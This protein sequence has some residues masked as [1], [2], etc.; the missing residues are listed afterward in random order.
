MIFLSTE[1][2]VEIHEEMISAWGG[3]A[4]G[5]P[6]GDSYEGVEAACQ[7]V[8]N[9][10]YEDLA[11]LAAAYAVY[12]VQGHVFADGNKRTGAGAMLVFLELNGA[13]TGISLED[14]A[15]AMVELQVRARKGERTDRLIAWLAKS[16]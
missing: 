3:A 6:R 15:S 12:I 10:Y 11:E 2:I 16:L 5:G 13:K 14:A 8:K 7:A 4:G 1:Q 9:S